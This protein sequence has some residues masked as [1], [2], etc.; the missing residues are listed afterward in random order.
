MSARRPIAAI[1]ILE[2]FFSTHPDFGHTA[3]FAILPIWCFDYEEPEQEPFCQQKLQW[4]VDHGYEVANHTWDHQDL[5]D[6]SADVF[7]QKILLRRDTICLMNVQHQAFEK[8]K[9]EQLPPKP[10]ELLIT[11][12]TGIFVQASTGVKLVEGIT[13]LK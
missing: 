8:I 2:D 5:T 9:D 12:L 10:N 4:L 7:L 11:W 13:F 1:A 6:V 3:L